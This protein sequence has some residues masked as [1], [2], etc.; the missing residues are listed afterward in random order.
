MADESII[1][2]VLRLLKDRK[3][4][5]TLT[6]ILHVA[7]KDF[8]Q[9]EDDVVAT[10]DGMLERGLLRLTTMKNK[11]SYKICDNISDT[12]TVFTSTSP[13]PTCISNARTVTYNASSNLAFAPEDSPPPL[14]DISFKHV[15][16]SP[17]L[18]TVDTHSPS[19]TV[20]SDDQ[21]R[22]NV[23]DHSLHSRDYL[24]NFDR[25]MDEVLNSVKTKTSIQVSEHKCCSCVNKCTDPSE[26]TLSTIISDLFSCLRKELDNKQKTID[27]L[28]DQLG[29]KTQSAEAANCT[30]QQKKSIND[31]I[32]RNIMTNYKTIS[33]DTPN[34]DAISDRNDGSLKRQV[35]NCFDRIDD[36]AS[37]EDNGIVA[38]SHYQ[39]NIT[40]PTDANG[41]FAANISI[42]NDQSGSNK[43]IEQLETV[44]IEWKTKHAAHV[45][46]QLRPLHFSQ[47][48]T[49]GAKQ[50][51]MPIT[52]NNNIGHAT[53]KSGTTVIAGDSMIRGLNE[54]RLSGGK[55]NVKVRSFPGASVTDMYSYLVPIISKRP[56]TIILQVG[57]NDACDNSSRDILH[58]FLDLKTFI[59]S[60]LPR[61]GVVL[62]SPVARFD[63]PKASLT[64]RRLGEH[65]K[66][67]KC[68][69]ISHDNIDGR[70]LGN[71]GLHPNDTGTGRLAHGC[72]RVPG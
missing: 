9:N 15:H 8:N 58:N 3:K 70:H 62:S 56:D 7:R 50:R 47:H 26:K 63:K 40:L 44:R 72:N 60:Q 13:T 22:A 34:S 2:K 25:Y 37:S 45:A 66:E 68:D 31:S 39:N 29:I 32:L 19:L 5:Q 36:N 28:I 35:P 54:S 64:V 23:K 4:G 51:S 27:L 20:N 11:V 18:I 53:W 16:N 12:L 48:R 69:S 55:R 59:L 65:L 61:C 33:M 30:A 10:L 6:N 17:D 43:L 49:L 46:D 42:T 24:L 1:Y 14:A 41:T 21:S 67:L 52:P 57:T 71:D 38:T